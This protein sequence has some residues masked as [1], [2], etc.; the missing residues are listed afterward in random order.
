[1]TP[2]PSRRRAGAVSR[3][4][5]LGAGALALIAAVA[6]SF[7]AAP[8]LRGALGAALAVVA[9][10]I[11]VVDSRSLTIPDAANAAAAAFGLASRAI[12]GGDPGAAIA[13]ALVRAFAM[14]ALF[15]A[16]QAAYRRLRAREGMGL[17]D[18]KLAAVAGL[19]LDAADLLIAID[20][21]CFA[22]LAFALVSRLGPG[23]APQA[24]TKL[25]FGAFLAP[26][27]WLCWLFAEW[28]G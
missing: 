19:W 26:S 27:I 28:R 6:A 13:A 14:A 8:N 24:A 7:A 23:R 16:F 15:L 17:G 2:S 11:A 9:A 18:V 1:M 4:V 22:A 12:G 3:F 10:V 25:P 20:I 5:G 21:A